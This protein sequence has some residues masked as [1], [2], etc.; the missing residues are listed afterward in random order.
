M[1]RVLSYK[2]FP[3]SAHAEN[4]ALFIMKAHD[5]SVPP[6]RELVKVILSMA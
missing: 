4:L 3:G 5:P 1:L 2:L 6:H